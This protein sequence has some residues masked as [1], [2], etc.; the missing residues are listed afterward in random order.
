MIEARTCLV[1]GAGASTSYGLPTGGQ[2]RDLILADRAVG[3]GKT[4]LRFLRKPLNERVDWPQWKVHAK[5]VGEWSNYL[6]ES[7]MASP[8]H[9]KLGTFRS[10]FFEGKVPS[11]DKFLQSNMEEF[12]EIGKLQIAAVLLNCEREGLL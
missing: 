3:A 1:L 8:E 5:A 7:S 9:G 2:L 4:A 12:G 6:F 11:I 10:R